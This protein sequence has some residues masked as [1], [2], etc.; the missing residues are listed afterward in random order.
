[1]PAIYHLREAAAAGGLMSYGT[2][3]T[4]AHRLAGTYTGR[5]LKGEPP[6]QL[7]VQQSTKFELV[8]NLFRQFSNSIVGAMGYGQIRQGLGTA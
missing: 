5:I 1:V 6:G 7:P 3:I 4:E 2:S 8:I